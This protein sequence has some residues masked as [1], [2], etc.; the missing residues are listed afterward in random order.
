[1]QRIIALCALCAIAPP[2]MAQLA[3][4]T[5]AATQPAKG[6]I[7]W[8][9]SLSYTQF[10]LAG[11]E[12]EQFETST[13]L[14][15]GITGELS[16]SLTFSYVDRNGT[17][18]SAYDQAGLSDTD[19]RLKW[20]FWQHDP[21]AIDTNRLALVGGLRLPTGTDGLSSDGYDPYVGLTFT[22]VQGRHGF[23]ASAFL[24]ITSDGQSAPIEAG[25]GPADLLTVE[26]SYLFRLLPAAYTSETNGSL[27]AVVE[28]IA[29]YEMNG[30]F[31]WRLA[32]GILWEAKRYALEL[33]VIVPVAREIDHRAE[34]DWGISAG[35][36]VLF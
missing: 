6:R 11:R 17:G 19:L 25:M 5:E 22:K 24:L 16:A 12:I 7:T 8:R 20:R 13:N 23:N 34:T 15:Y 21:G 32:P 30:D 31:A 18:A 26:S 35:L 4:L 9:Q 10:E 3:P 29:D 36:R 28:S 2:A 27:Y 14:S 33:S 1:M